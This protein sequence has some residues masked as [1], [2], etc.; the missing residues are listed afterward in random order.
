MRKK[1]LISI[2]WGVL[3][4]GILALPGKSGENPAPKAEQL[5]REAMKRVVYYLPEQFPQLPQAARGYL[6]ANRY[7]IPQVGLGSTRRGPGNAIRGQ[8]YGKGR[9]DWAV[10]ASKDGISRILVFREGK[11]KPDELAARA[12]WRSISRFRPDQPQQSL[13]FVREI[14]PMGEK[15]LRHYHEV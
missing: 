14:L 4:L 6:I 2:V 1:P 5:R 7:S 8:F 3:F 12:D 11:G 9:E 15:Y 13:R 10:L